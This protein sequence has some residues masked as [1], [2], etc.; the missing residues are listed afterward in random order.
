MDPMQPARIL[1]V[2]DS[3]AIRLPVQTALTA[4]GFRVDAAS[5][6]SPN[7]SGMSFVSASCRQSTSA[8]WSL[9]ARSVTRC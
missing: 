1:V 4:R 7:S 6:N 2:E 9:S 8:W 3:E 5:E